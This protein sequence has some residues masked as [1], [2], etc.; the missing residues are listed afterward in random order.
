MELPSAC[1]VMF[2]SVLKIVHLPLL[3]WAV[4]LGQIYVSAEFPNTFYN[5][6]WAKDKFKQV[7]GLAGHY[8]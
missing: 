7:Y 6:T 8:V 3:A 1:E 5:H 4:K 2:S